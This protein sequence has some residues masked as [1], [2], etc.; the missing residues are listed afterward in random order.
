MPIDG[1]LNL[2]VFDLFAADPILDIDSNE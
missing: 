2:N 1:V